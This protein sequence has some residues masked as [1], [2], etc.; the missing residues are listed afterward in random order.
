MTIFRNRNVEAVQ[1][2]EVVILGADPADV[3]SVLT[4]PGLSQ[5]LRG[6]LL[7]SVVAGW[8]REKLEETLR[9]GLDDTI[10]YSGARSSKESRVWVLRTLPNI[11]ALVSQSLTAIEE[12]G[13]EMP[14]HY[15]ELAELILQQIGRIVRVTPQLID[16][17]TAVGGST[18]AF[19]AVICDAMIDAAV[20]VGVPRT[21]PRP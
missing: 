7:I 18:P 4:Q 19:F 17:T 2:S 15:L 3:E 21:P 20:A 11:A 1:R 16:A 8:T 10:D 9:G 14:S 6:K 5:G 12:P 13:P